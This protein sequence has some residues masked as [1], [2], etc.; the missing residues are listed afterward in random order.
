MRLSRRQVIGQALALGLSSA[1]TLRAAPAAPTEGLKDL[2]ARR[3]LFYGCAMKSGQLSQDPAFVQAVLADCSA[4]VPEYELKRI[5]TEPSPGRYD[6]SGADRLAAFAQKNDL[7]LRGHTLVWHMSNPAWLEVELASSPSIEK[8]MFSYIERATQRYGRRIVGWDVV[9]EAIA[10]E[11]GDPS[12]LRVS[13]PWYKAF[14]SR[15]IDDAFHCARANL[16]ETP[17]FYNDYGLE[18]QGR[19]YTARR[20]TLLKL[21]EGLKA[22]NVPID[23][24][25]IQSHLLTYEHGFD[26]ETFARF[27]ADIA[28][29]GLKIAI[30]EFDVTDRKGPSDIAARDNEAAVL[31]KR[32]MDVALDCKAL[33]GIL[34][35]GLSDRYFW[36]P[37]D[38]AMRRIDGQT[39]RPLPLDSELRRKPMWDAIAAALRG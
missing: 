37:D 29:L 11:D 33:I 22:R 35:W 26:E 36:V 5:I 6:F 16:P 14:G 20:A 1:P 28:S 19:W 34:S 31:T 10:P 30:T 23:A 18:M 17:L 32:F 8:H 21:L 2:A 9:N 4:I 15:Y 13:S 27:L 25:G 3:G 38:P 7:L 24:V 12:G 39:L